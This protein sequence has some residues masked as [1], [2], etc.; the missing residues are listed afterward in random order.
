MSRLHFSRQAEIDLTEI[1]EYVADDNLDA[2]DTLVF[3][4]R[5]QARLIATQP[6]MGKKRFDLAPELR[7]FSMAATCC[8]IAQGKAAASR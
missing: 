4:I 1:W 7:S 8:S 6:Q 5:E 2:A 3:R